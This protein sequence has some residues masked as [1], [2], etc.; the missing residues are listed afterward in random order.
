MQQ[1]QQ[2]PIILLRSLLQR[3]AYSLATGAILIVY[4][5]WLF[6]GNYD[7]AG[8]AVSGELW[9]TWI[10]YSLMAAIFLWLVRVF[11]V[12]S[13]WALFLAGAIYGWIAEGI[14]VQTMYND[15]PMNISFTG[16]AWHALLS[17]LVGWYLVRKALL[18]WKPLSV[19]LLSTGIG[20]AWGIWSVWWWW[21]KKLITPVADFV[22]YAIICYIILIM[23]YWLVNRLRFDVF[24]PSK[25]EVGLCAAL[26]LFTY[27]AG[28]VPANA[29]ALWVLPCCLGL[30]GYGLYQNRK[31]EGDLD[32][33]GRIEGPIPLINFAML[34]AVPLTAIGVYAVMH[35][36]QWVYPFGWWWYAIT[37]PSGFGLFIVSIIKINKN[38]RRHAQLNQHTV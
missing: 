37:V 4:S 2:S 15:F 35:A 27:V 33:F 21:E 20:V 28:A 13:L 9:V 25:I 38:R 32:L 34:A 29:M 1:R 3:I 17:V 8:Q 7:F 24:H 6:W 14:V 12:N 26:V 22:S 16:L 23:G 36:V 18:G 30:A 5:E 10:A 11:R 31:T 19:L